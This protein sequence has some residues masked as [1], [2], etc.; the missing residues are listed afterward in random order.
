MKTPVL[1]LM[2]GI[3]C[4]LF[5]GPSI[6]APAT[7]VLADQSQDSSVL[8]PDDSDYSDAMEFALFLRSNGFIV[9]S[10]HRSKM[11]GFFRGIRRRLLE[12][13]TAFSR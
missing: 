13:I 10:L 11:S 5:A 1:F 6:Q 3:Q 12:R 4:T 8:Q 9:H 7:S 2:Y